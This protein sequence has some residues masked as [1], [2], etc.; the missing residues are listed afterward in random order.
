MHGFIVYE[1]RRFE[2]LEELLTLFG[3]HCH[4]SFNQQKDFDYIVFGIHGP[5]EL[6]RYK[7]SG[8]THLLS[9]DF[10]SNLKP[11][12]HLYTFCFN[13]YLA[14]M[15]KKHHL[16]Y[17]T[18]ESDETIIDG[19]A[20]L[21]SEATIAWLIENRPQALKNSSI[22]IFG[23]GH[24]AKSLVRYLHP[25]VKKLKIISRSSR[26]DGYLSMYAKC[27]RFFDEGYLD[28]DIFINTIPARILDDQ[29]I[30]L[31]PPLTLVDLSSFP[32]GVQLEKAL[33]KGIQ[34]V[35]LPGLPAKYAYQDSAKL[36]FDKMIEERKNA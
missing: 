19:N 15:A 17:H 14:L 7:E 16:V 23:N 21:T 31:N 32:Y 6:G 22:T 20:D 12:C 35:I 25:I 27:Y 30:H 3:D 33:E 9:S 18:F 8:I 5:D 24:L 10:F 26:D 29:L 1:D 11:N 28:S 4:H 36:L 13:P 34:A 2:Y